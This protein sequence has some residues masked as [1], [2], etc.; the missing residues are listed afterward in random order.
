M[1]KKTQRDKEEALKLERKRPLSDPI[2]RRFYTRRTGVPSQCLRKSPPGNTSVDEKIPSRCCPLTD[3]RYYVV[4]REWCHRWRKYIRTGEGGPCGA[5]DAACLVCDAHS[6]LLLPPHLESFLAGDNPQ[7]LASHD[8][9][10]DVP[11]ETPQSP[12]MARAA[13]PGQAPDQAAA[14]AMM[15]AGLSTSQISQQLSALRLLEQQRVDQN[16]MLDNIDAPVAASTPS[17]NELLD[18]E[19]HSVVEILSQQEYQALEAFWPPGSSFGLFMEIRQGRDVWG[20]QLCRDCD[21][22]GR[23]HDFHVKN[24]ARGWVKKSSDK[25]RAPA[26]LEY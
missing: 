11:S 26:S 21:A 15:E 1:T 12:I 17:K 9:F 18:R 6:L 8:F 25:A 24:R 10:V 5:P 23:S 14:R 3:G 16:V 4:P 22:T 7:L 19:N 2:L 13:I 20:T